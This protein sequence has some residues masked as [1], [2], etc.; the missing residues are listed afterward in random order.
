MKNSKFIIGNSSAGV[1]EAPVFG[2]PSINIGSRQNNR[3]THPSIINVNENETEI[4]NAINNIPDRFTPSLNFGKGKSA[5]LYMKTISKK[6][7]WKIPNQ[8]QFKDL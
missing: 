3:S 2:V 1:R 8:K 6:L 4:N 7:F 5:K